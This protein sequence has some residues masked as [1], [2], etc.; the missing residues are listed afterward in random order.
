MPPCLFRRV[1]RSSGQAGRELP[2]RSAWRMVAV[3][4]SIAWASV[5]WVMRKVA[6]IERMPP[7]WWEVRVRYSQT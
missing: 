5:G 7:L 4:H 3:I 2:Q 6:L 1:W